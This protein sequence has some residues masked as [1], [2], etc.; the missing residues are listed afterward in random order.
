[1]NVITY[2]CHNLNWTMLINKNPDILHENRIPY[3]YA[4]HNIIAL[5]NP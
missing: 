2:P 4:S 5:V 3:N 1:M